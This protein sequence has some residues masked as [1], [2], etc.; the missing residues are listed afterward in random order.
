MQFINA[1]NI[2]KTIHMIMKK[3]DCEKIKLFMRLTFRVNRMSD[4]SIKIL[5]I[6]YCQ[7]A[8][9]TDS[10]KTIIMDERKWRQLPT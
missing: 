3:Y 8:K 1:K 5:F 2:Q 6:K 7:L 10:K 9:K 4:V